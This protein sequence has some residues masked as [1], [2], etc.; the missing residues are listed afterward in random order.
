MFFRTRFELFHFEPNSEGPT[1]KVHDESNIDM[2]L[3][4]LECFVI[5]DTDLGRTSLTQNGTKKGAK[6]SKLPSLCPILRAQKSRTSPNLLREQ[7]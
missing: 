5:A 2:L 6:E 7:T 1:T 4:S 3:R